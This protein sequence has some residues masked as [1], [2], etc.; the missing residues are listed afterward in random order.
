MQVSTAI[1]VN[2]MTI[3]LPLVRTLTTALASG[4]PTPMITAPR[5][6]VALAAAVTDDGGRVLA[7]AAQR[8]AAGSRPEVCWSWGRPSWTVCGAK[9]AKRPASMSSPKHS[10]RC[11]RT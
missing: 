10:A 7:I 1:T 3:L 11:T 8:M 9:P 6:L 2:I 4:S 5:H